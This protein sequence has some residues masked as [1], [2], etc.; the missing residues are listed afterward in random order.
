MKARRGRL[1]FPSRGTDRAPSWGGQRFALVSLW[2]REKSFVSVPEVGYSFHNCSAKQLP[3]QMP[4]H[5]F[6][7]RLQPLKKRIIPILPAASASEL[8]TL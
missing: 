1:V 3:E 2:R 4:A 7:S 8:R 6:A 5:A